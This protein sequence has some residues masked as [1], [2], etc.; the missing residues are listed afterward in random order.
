MPS[1]T[2]RVNR[3]EFGNGRNDEEKLCTIVPNQRV[4]MG[5]QIG[6]Q[7]RYS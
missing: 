5:Q 6:N 1:L 7:Y 3:L 2:R 4:I